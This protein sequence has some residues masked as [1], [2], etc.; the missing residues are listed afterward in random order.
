MTS[1]LT[2]RKDLTRWNRAGLERLR[3]IE[4]N[5]ITLLEEM[6]HQLQ[7]KF[8]DWEYVNQDVADEA[9]SETKI[10]ILDQ[11]ADTRQD[12]GWEIARAFV[13]AT[14]T[15]TEHVDAFANEG[16]ISTA[17]QWEYLRRLVA[18]LDY[19]PLPPASASTSIAIIAKEDSEPGTVNAGLQMKHT[20]LDGGAPVIFETLEDIE[21][22]PL[23]N[24]LFLDG[25]DQNPDPFDPFSDHASGPFWILPDKSGVTVG[26]PAVLLSNG[27]ASAVSISDVEEGRVRI[28]G[29][30]QFSSFARKA[31]KSEYILSQTTLWVEPGNVHVPHLN[32][33]DVLRFDNAGALSENQIVVWKKSGTT[34]FAR[35]EATDRYTVRLT[36]VIPAGS[37]VT[38]A[39]VELFVAQ[40]VPNEQ[41]QANGNGEW[42]FP[43]KSLAG[44]LTVA[45][46]SSGALTGSLNSSHTIETVGE[47]D[48]PDENGF[49]KITSFSGH[50]MYFYLPSEAV[51]LATSIAEPAVGHFTFDGGA[52]DLG[53][54]DYLVAESSAGTKSAVEVESVRELESTFELT[55]AGG[56]NALSGVARLHGPFKDRLRPLGH[57][58]NPHPVT[59][60][61]LTLALQPEDLPQ[62]LAPGKTVLIET[63]DEQPELSAFTAKVIDVETYGVGRVRPKKKRRLKAGKPRLVLDAASEKFNGYTKG[64]TI[65]RANV[66]AAGHGESKPEKALGSGDA[67]MASQ[68]FV[69][70]KKNVSFTADSQ[71]ESGVRAAATVRVD[72]RLYEEVSSLASS[73]PSDAHYATRITEDGLVQI[74]FGDGYHGRRLP[75]GRNN[76]TAAVRTGTGSEGNNLPPGS[77]ETLAKPHILVDEVRQPIPTSGGQEIEDIAGIREN[78]PSHLKAL[79]RGVSLSDFEHLSRSQPGVWHAKAFFNPAGAE[80]REL[81]EISVVPADG[82]PLGDLGSVLEDRL[83]A[84]APPGLV[85]TVSR[86]DPVHLPLSIILRVDEEGFDYDKVEEAVF[87]AVLERFSL[88]NKPPAAPVYLSEVYQCVEG[89]EGVR[90]SDVSMFAGFEDD[91]IVSLS[92]RPLKHTPRNEADEIWAVWPQDNQS[93]YVADRQSITISR[94]EATI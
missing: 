3:Y 78:A 58:R 47:S 80:R 21:I 75:T 88:T 33:A 49:K 69:I 87:E 76:V 79:G 6:R 93:V 10:R 55:L 71:M 68:T 38:G 36:D 46:T 74:S 44:L 29:S 85:F 67:A 17:T 41:F 23:L 15:L 45:G 39:G 72:G 73:E 34:G 59:P 82:A 28:S 14:H 27:V 8:P 56:K 2:S 5:A 94:E 65:I 37:D 64:N 92:N 60:N 83:S 62:L 32:G 86:F 9:E 30:A 12:W 61:E 22:D 70:N 4:G 42:R 25:W 43:D 31:V 77:L 1:H 19:R 54:G 48:D 52:G 7:G 18:M 51:K 26:Q 84:L 40:H 63:V 81:V 11:Y 13:R 91:E 57:D 50:S 24:G 53:A 35:I 89:I 16:Y 20:P 66:A 90:N